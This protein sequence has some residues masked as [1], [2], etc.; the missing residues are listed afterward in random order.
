MLDQ[1]VVSTTQQALAVDSLISSHAINTSVTNPSDIE[2]IFDMI[3]YKKGSCLIQMIEAFMGREALQ[4]GL[5]IYLERYKY[6]TAKTSDL[7]QCFSEVSF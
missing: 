1:F 3:S 5:E 2:A 4:A 7:W 6:Q